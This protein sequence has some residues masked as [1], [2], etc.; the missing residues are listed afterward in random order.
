[1]NT[2]NIQPFHVIGIS[3]RTTNEN[4]QSGIDIPA[5]WNRFMSEAIAQKIPGTSGPAI[6]CV[7]TGYEKDHTTPYTTVLGCKV[8]DLYNIPE[9]MTGITIES[10]NYTK[11][12]VKGNILS[13]IIFDEWNK[14]WNA[15]LPRTYTADFEVYGER[16]QNPED[17][18]VDIFI[19]VE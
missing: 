2:Q 13:G 16:A 7:Y 14:I 12:V 5:L 8:D 18:E 4:G 10:G 15:G 9:G 11:R 6:Y 17:A 19:A 3:V 1:M